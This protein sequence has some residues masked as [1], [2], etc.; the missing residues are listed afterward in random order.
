MI[1]KFLV[2]TSLT[3]VTLITATLSAYCTRRI[4]SSDHEEQSLLR[5]FNILKLEKLQTKTKAEEKQI[6]SNNAKES[7]TIIKN[8][9]AIYA[10]KIITQQ[11][12]QDKQSK[13]KN[14]F[15]SVE[16]VK[17]NDK[18]NNIKKKSTDKKITTK[19]HVKKKNTPFKIKQIC[20]ITMTFFPF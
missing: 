14:I 2:I 11:D 20:I 16:I 5:Y 7:N 9:Q 17:G 18:K 12:R 15:V 1:R 4:G 6:K 13:L 3:I 19:R 8:V 10:D